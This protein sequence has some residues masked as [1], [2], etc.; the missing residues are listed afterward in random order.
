MAGF[1]TPHVN[2]RLW[3]APCEQQEMQ[4]L[5]LCL[6]RAGLPSQSSKIL[7][8]PRSFRVVLPLAKLQAYHGIQ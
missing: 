6:L 7:M 2:C 1:G 5:A 4:L 8:F 3:N